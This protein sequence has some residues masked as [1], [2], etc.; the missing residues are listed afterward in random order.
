MPKLP[1][2]EP[3]PPWPLRWRIVA[4]LALYGG[5]ALVCL[6]ALNP[7][8]RTTPGLGWDKLNHLLAFTTLSL[9]AWWAHPG[10]RLRAML[11]LFCFGLLIEVVQSTMPAHQAEAGDLLADVLGIAMGVWSARL[12]QARAIFARR[13]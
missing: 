2:P 12:L 3:T 1:P 8:A 13:R 7:H 11:A 9:A 10:M 6:I 4:R 5:I